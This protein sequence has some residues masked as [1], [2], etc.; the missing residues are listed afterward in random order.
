[1]ATVA[2]KSADAMAFMIAVPWC[3]ALRNQSDRANA[4]ELATGTTFLDRAS[5][6][7]LALL[8]PQ[9]GIRGFNRPIS[10]RVIHSESVHRGRVGLVDPVVQVAVVRSEAEGGPA[11]RQPTPA[12]P[13]RS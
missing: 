5:V 2:A 8:L 4:P 13:L 6:R 11:K 9:D 1:M 12:S 7:G 10:L 3:L